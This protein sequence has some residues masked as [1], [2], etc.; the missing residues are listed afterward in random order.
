[1][2]GFLYSELWILISN[3]FINH[4]LIN[5]CSLAQNQLF[6]ESDVVIDVILLLCLVCDF[7]YTVSLKLDK[8]NGFLKSLSSA[9][10]AL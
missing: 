5:F 8:W 6:L 4:F 10:P 2:S 7:P 1:M 9:P 3:F